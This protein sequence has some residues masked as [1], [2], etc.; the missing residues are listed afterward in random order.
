MASHSSLQRTARVLDVFIDRIGQ[1]TGWFSLALV[2][3][4][5]GN[6]LMRYLF[7]TGSVALQELEWHL[8]APVCMLGI[9]Y[10]LLRD[11]HV[12]VDVFYGRFSVKTQ[13][14]I[15]FIS[16][17]AV[18]L[19]AALLV[20]LSIPYVEQSWRIG[21]SS[22]DPGGL[23]HRWILKA[24]IPLGFV[25]LTIQSFAATLKTWIAFVEGSET[26]AMKVE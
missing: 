20:W 15:D 8:M 13:R 1:V 16:M 22:P 23:T 24:I 4:M 26:P 12:Q 7:R 9:S 21:E 17:L 2:L 3:V 6:V 18:T 25:L 5:A 14:F 11:G 19:I 10:A